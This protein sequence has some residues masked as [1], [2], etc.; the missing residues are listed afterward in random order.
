[1]DNM[2]LVLKIQAVFKGRPVK[3][4]SA[5]HVGD[6]AVPSHDALVVLLAG[7]FGWLF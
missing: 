3:W 6:I 1:M 7:H 2:T 4:V 5:V